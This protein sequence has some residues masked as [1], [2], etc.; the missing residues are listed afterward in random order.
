MYASTFDFP[1]HCGPQLVPSSAFSQNLRAVLSA[2]EWKKFR[3]AVFKKHGMVCSFCGSK[4]KSLDCH[5]IWQYQTPIARGEMGRQVLI[6]VLP[7]CKS[8]H[9]VCHIGFWSLKGNTDHIVAHMCKVRKITKEEAKKEVASAFSLHSKLSE[10]EYIL[11]IAAAS[12]Y[13]TKPE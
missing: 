3:E 8:C 5:E 12:S 13:I 2:S 11:D 6:K 9:Q 10:F 7:L 1:E 4:P